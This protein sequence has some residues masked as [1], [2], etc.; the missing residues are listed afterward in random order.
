MP[1]SA[2][3]CRNPLIFNY[4]LVHIMMYKHT[5]FHDDV[6]SGT[7]KLRNEKKRNEAKRKQNPTKSVK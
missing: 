1:R 2:Y 7:G 4:L 3:I 5:K 6:N